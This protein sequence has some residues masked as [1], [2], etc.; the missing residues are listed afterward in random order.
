MRRFKFIF[1]SRYRDRHEVYLLPSMI[2]ALRVAEQITSEHAPQYG[3][4]SNV[5]IIDLGEETE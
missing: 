1:V 5:E 3:P 2:H 4:I